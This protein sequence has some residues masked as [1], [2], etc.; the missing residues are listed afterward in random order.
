MLTRRGTIFIPT[1]R[2]GRVIRNI[3]ET[4]FC[5]V[6]RKIHG[7]RIRDKILHYSAS[8]WSIYVYVEQ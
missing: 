4:A 1:F 6:D 2:F 3:C 8:R 5:A 7:V